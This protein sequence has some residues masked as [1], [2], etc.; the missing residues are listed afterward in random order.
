MQ[1]SVIVKNSK[2]PH[3]DWQLHIHLKRF[4]HAEAV[5]EYS[6]RKQDNSAQGCN[7]R[8]LNRDGDKEAKLTDCSF[9]LL[10]KNL[11]NINAILLPN[12]GIISIPK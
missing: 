12:A 4:I 5:P 8:F 10:N 1:E 6:P 2:H 11:E 3:R 9:N 7:S